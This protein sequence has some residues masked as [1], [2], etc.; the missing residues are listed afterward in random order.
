MEV[1]VL[2]VTCVLQMCNDCGVFEDTR[3]PVSSQIFPIKTFIDKKGT[4][5]ASIL[6][7]FN[8][9]G[10]ARRSPVGLK[11]QFCILLHRKAFGSQ[12]NEHFPQVL[13]QDSA[14]GPF[15]RRSA[16]TAA[17]LLPS[18]LQE[19]VGGADQHV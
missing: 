11:E 16:I 5:V 10:R 1:S 14:N 8:V 12:R 19:A 4:V 15:A 3:K 13:L 6:T 18:P 9:Y 17:Q 7:D 2:K